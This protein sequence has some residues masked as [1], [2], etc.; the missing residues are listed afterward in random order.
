MGRLKM[1]KFLRSLIL[2]LIVVTAFVA[3]PV[4]AE[5][6]IVSTHENIF[7][8]NYVG[9]V[10][11]ENGQEETLNEFASIVY[12]RLSNDENVRIFGIEINYY[13]TSKWGEGNVLK[14]ARKTAGAHDGSGDF[15][16]AFFDLNDGYYSAR[17]FA[18]HEGATWDEVE[19]GALVYFT[20]GDS[21]KANYSIEYYFEDE[22]GDFV[23]DASK[24]ETLKGSIG[25]NVTAS[26]PYFPGY[27]NDPLQG[28]ASGMIVANTDIT[29]AEGNVTGKN[30]LVLSLYYAIDDTQVYYDFNGGV[31]SEGNEGVLVDRDGGNTTATAPSNLTAPGLVHTG[32]A[33]DNTGATVTESTEGLAVVYATWEFESSYF[34]YDMI[35]EGYWY[36]NAEGDDAFDTHGVGK[37]V[38]PIYSHAY[39]NFF[40]G[41]RDNAVVPTDW[42][43]DGHYVM[44]ST[45]QNPTHDTQYVGSKIEMPAIALDT[46]E[47][48]TIKYIMVSSGG[49]ISSN[50]SYIRANA[51][52]TEND[53]TGSIAI[54]GAG[55]SFDTALT[56]TITKDELVSIMPE[57]DNTELKALY[58]D[59]LNWVSNHI[60]IDCIRFNTTDEGWVNH[61]ENNYASYT[62]EHYLEQSDG[63]YAVG[64]TESFY[65]S[66]GGS[67]ST[68]K[69]NARTFDTHVFNENHESNVI[70]A[71]L[72]ADGSTVLKLYYDAFSTNVVYD[73]NGGTDANGA[74]STTVN[75]VSS[76]DTLISGEDLNKDGYV[77]MGWSTSNQTNTINVDEDGLVG[78]AT[79]FY[80]VWYDL[81]WLEFGDATANAA[82][83]AGR[84]DSLNATIDDAESADGL[85]LDLSIYQN[86]G[87]GNYRYGL[88]RLPNVKVSDL[89]NIK[90]RFKA[91]QAA[92][93]TATFNTVPTTAA[94][95]DKNTFSLAT[96]TWTTITLTRTDIA[97]A[98]SD[99]V[100]T[101]IVLSGAYGQWAD[102]GESGK[103]IYID[104]VEITS[105]DDDYPEVQLN[106]TYDYNGGEDALSNTTHS[107]TVAAGSP[108][109]DGTGLVREGYTFFGWA[110]SA[111][112][113]TFADMKAAGDRAD[114]GI[115]DTEN[116][117]YYAVWY[118]NDWLS[119]ND[120]EVNSLIIGGSYVRTHTTDADGDSVEETI[121]G[122]RIQ[123]SFANRS[124][125][126]QILLPRIAI[127]DIQSIDYKAYV[128]GFNWGNLGSLSSTSSRWFGL[129]INGL[130]TSTDNNDNAFWKAAASGVLTDSTDAAEIATLIQGNSVTESRTYL[131]C[132]D[133][134]SSQNGDSDL[135]FDYIN[136]TMKPA[137]IEYTT[138]Y[139]FQQADGSYLINEEM[140]TT[141]AGVDGSIV[142]AV[143][144]PVDG[145][146]VD[147][148]NVNAVLSGTVASDLTLKVYYNKVSAYATEYYLEDANGDFVKNDEYTTQSTGEAL[149]EAVAE[150]K[151]IEGYTLDESNENAVASATI[152]YDGSTVLKLY[153]KIT[154]VS[155]VYDWGEGTQ[156]V[157]HVP[158]TEVSADVKPTK[159]GYV[160]NGWLD[161]QGNEVTTITEACTLTA[162]W[163]D[164]GMLEMSK[165]PSSKY[166]GLQGNGK[167]HY[168]I[169]VNNY[170]ANGVSDEWTE[171]GYYMGFATWQNPSHASQ[172]V[173]TV[174]HLPDLDLDALTSITIKFV[175]LND[176]CAFADRTNYLRAN[177]AVTTNS[178]AGV[179]MTGTSAGTPVELT[180]TKE[181]LVATM[182][183][184]DREVLHTLYI[185]G[186]NYTATRLLIDY[187]RINSTQAEIVDYNENHFATLT[188]E[189]Y[190]GDENGEFTKSD[191]LT[192]QTSVLI[193]TEVVE[194]GK[195]LAG[196]TFDSANENSVL[197]GTMTAE[198]LTL[199]SYYTLNKSEVTYDFNG[200]VDGEGLESATL[201]Q[202]GT[203]ALMDGTGLVNGDLIFYGWAT[204]ANVTTFAD[205]KA[206]AERAES[207]VVGANTEYFAV[208][209]DL[210]WLEF[211]NSET[212]KLI[213]SGPNQTTLEVNGGQTEGARLNQNPGVSSART[214]TILLPNIV[215]DDL[216]TIEFMGYKA[217]AAGTLNTGARD[218]YFGIN[219]TLQAAT[220]ESHS[221]YISASSGIVNGTRTGAQLKTLAQSELA[222]A[223]KDKLMTLTIGGNGWN[224]EYLFVDYLRIVMLDETAT[225]TTEHYVEQADGSYVR[226]DELT[227]TERGAIGATANATPATISGYEYNAEHA[228]SVTTG[229]IAEDGSLVLKLY[230]NIVRAT[231][232]YNYNGGTDGVGGSTTVKQLGSEALISN[233]GITKD[234]YV[235]YGWSTVENPT[236]N[237]VDADGLVG[238]DTTFYAVWYDLS[239]LSTNMAGGLDAGIY[240]GGG[241][242]GSAALSENAIKFRIWHPPAGG[243]YTYAIIKLPKLDMDE[244]VSITLNVTAGATTKHS[245]F[246]NQTSTTSSPGATLAVSQNLTSGTA[247]D[248]VLTK[249]ALANIT[250]TG[251]E[252]H[253]LYF[254]LYSAWSDVYATLNGI[255][256]V[257]TQEGFPEPKIRVVYDLNDGSGET[258]TQDVEADSPIMDGTTLTREGYTFYGWSTTASVTTF[259]GMQEASALADNGTIT[260]AATYYAVWYGDD[261]LNFNDSTVNSMIL[262]GS[263]VKTHTSDFDGDGNADNTV[264]GGR[265][266]QVYGWG[267]YTH[268]QVLLPRIPVADI[269][270]L[271]VNA[272]NYG[273]SWGSLG[274]AKTTARWY[275]FCLN[276]LCVGSS[277][278]THSFSVA[279]TTTGTLTATADASKLASCMSSE[280][281]TAGTTY[282]KFMDIAATQDGD[283]DVL[284]DSIVITKNA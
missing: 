119:F 161:G 216:W 17:A 107:E 1:K 24:T 43:E 184:D 239:W 278:Q 62:V 165:A 126:I 71:E 111:S 269:A 110:T 259:A 67:V 120:S 117:T 241:K 265:V 33:K 19:Y 91:S 53:T 124:M 30:K 233:E 194:N 6:A 32:W 169:G 154:K 174:I 61:Y 214:L 31:D 96:T 270:S 85:G 86:A 49:A 88:I 280:L 145:W 271:T 218:F 196:Y 18:L 244:L 209:Y 60:L 23:R 70:E 262:S 215:F 40:D 132:V 260:A 208:W 29:D 155:V 203:E 157:D 192:R 81:D 193:G 255:T 166:Y 156:T 104:Y 3:V 75:G 134:A 34:A 282:L 121:S 211:N 207:G 28:V 125:H 56:L 237:D 258:I 164:L 89:I 225:Y 146:A 256:I 90:I 228:S 151:V 141:T 68:I 253:T 135:L 113:T 210:D 235:F 52:G 177:T 15:G 186:Y 48:I 251:D 264:G 76:I 72:A 217:A 224:D 4:L 83:T 173:G 27:E 98:C 133:V 138:E 226:N 257:T 163:Y 12:G 14:R 200:G 64:K 261:W 8:G 84:Y 130:I 26:A 80:A 148:D 197:S 35:A 137:E 66:K 108:L 247:M 246:I 268:L 140:T 11:N 245:V 185:D 13:G 144:T 2:V 69:A 123:D 73:Y 189:Y 63:S 22:N 103:Y 87:G 267:S 82:I 212:N 284:I 275:V 204:S 213:L 220:M 50:T 42:T 170:A 243:S 175:T 129:A 65:V 112:V 168:G 92:K 273:F 128:Y 205:M 199:K 279:S 101:S 37:N 234:G 109:M 188:R 172:Y 152:A 171:D 57:D 93:I 51:P 95:S 231:V 46:L 178:N 254:G 78:S 250:T 45:W 9:T 38:W 230:Y 167:G 276:G 236:L 21:Y 223:S 252:V 283:C 16:I 206:A 5:S 94:S 36:D 55:G 180:I 176:S 100:L 131:R 221:F 20:V 229:T 114:T 115:V 202:Y 58:L 191:A 150:V 248:F 153:Y 240:A 99:D 122:A 118:G 195:T 47:S 127:S 159:S 59:G 10:I 102:F 198:G 266:N 116:A 44:F 187:I 227:T 232:T 136:I 142:S 7:Q 54:S 97:A 190:L 219:G 25:G 158:G 201:S 222:T 162:N 238:T 274:T 181:D 182:A 139:Y 183:E 106:V 41:V 143:Q 242:A 147:A 281:V 39:H 263:Y 149:A 272:Y 74:A 79:Y 77:F 249:E 160:L 105:L 179:V 277:D